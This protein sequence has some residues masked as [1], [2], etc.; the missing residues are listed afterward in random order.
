[1]PARILAALATL[2]VEMISLGASKINLTLVVPD[3][4]AHD[5]VRRLHGEFFP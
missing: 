3:A 1:V 4:Y 2:P 5:A